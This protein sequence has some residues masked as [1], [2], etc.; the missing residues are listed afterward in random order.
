MKIKKNWKKN[1]VQGLLL[2]WELTNHPKH[3]HQK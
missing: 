1:E 3:M 2:Q